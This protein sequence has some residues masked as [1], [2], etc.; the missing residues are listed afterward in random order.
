MT[1]LCRSGIYETWVFLGKTDGSG[2]LRVDVSDSKSAM[3][4]FASLLQQAILARQLRLVEINIGTPAPDVVILDIGGRRA[5]QFPIRNAATPFSILI[6]DFVWTFAVFSAA[7]SVQVSA[8]IMVDDR[9]NG[10]R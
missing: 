6:D 7:A 9:P 10:P 1:E 5:G 3:G 4:P 2:V 8:R